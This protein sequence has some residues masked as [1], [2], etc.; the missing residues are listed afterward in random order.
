M[1]W[2]THEVPAQCFGAPCTGGFKLKTCCCE[3]CLPQRFSACASR[4]TDLSRL[5]VASQEDPGLEE[6]SLPATPRSSK[7]GNGLLPGASKTATKLI[8]K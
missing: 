8:W 1:S 5:G 4:C 6:T 2:L 3:N 7:P